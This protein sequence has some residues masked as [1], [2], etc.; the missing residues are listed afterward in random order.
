MSKII[1]LRFRT[2]PIVA[3]EIKK[4]AK[5]FSMTKSELSESLLVLGLSQL[6]NAINLDC[7]IK[8]DRLPTASCLRFNI[9]EAK[10]SI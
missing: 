10:N 3:D 9:G 7:L 6:K 2:I 4:L 8:I 1:E 5:H